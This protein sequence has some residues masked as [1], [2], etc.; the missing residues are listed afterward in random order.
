MLGTNNDLYHNWQMRPGISDNANW[1]GRISCFSGDSAYQVAAASNADGRMETFYV[2]TNNDLYHN[3]QVN[4]NG[5]WTK[6]PRGGRRGRNA[7]SSGKQYQFR[8]EQQ[9]QSVEMS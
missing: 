3:W 9:L 5:N 8:I 2:G 1:A 4:P 6:L 7:C